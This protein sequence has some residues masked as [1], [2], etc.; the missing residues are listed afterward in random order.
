[1][2]SFKVSLLYCTG[3]LEPSLLDSCSLSIH[4]IFL[5][6]LF[7]PAPGCLGLDK[8]PLM[9]VGD[10]DIGE[11]LVALPALCLCL[12]LPPYAAACAIREGGAFTPLK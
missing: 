5:D 6:L 9:S 7:Y 12:N 8:V 11:L 3:E 2:I 4:V 10:W 1:M